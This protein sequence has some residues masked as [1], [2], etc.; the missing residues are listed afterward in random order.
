MFS[1]GV[2][3]LGL[4]FVFLFSSIS[5]PTHKKQNKVFYVDFVGAST[6]TNAGAKGGGNGEKSS[7]K[8]VKNDKNDVKKLEND[9]KSA[10]KDALKIPQQKTGQ[11]DQSKNGKKISKKG[12]SKDSC[13]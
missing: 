8:D 4:A 6:V 7:E 10:E 5:L 11:Q 3:F 1:S 13:Q 9:K 12:L 2:H